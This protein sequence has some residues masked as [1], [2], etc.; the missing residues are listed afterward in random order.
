MLLEIVREDAIC[1]L[2]MTVP[3]VG[4]VTALTFRTAVDAIHR[5]DSSRLVAA[6]FGLTPRVHSSGEMEQIGRITKC[7]DTM[8]RAMLYE[9]ANVMMTRYRATSGSR[10]GRSASPRP[11]TT[12]RSVKPADD[13][14]SKGNPV[15]PL[16]KVS[17]FNSIPLPIAGCG[18]RSRQPSF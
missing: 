1:R 13:E 17:S 14:R 5:F 2:L 15:D 7:G 18:G 4:P 12:N 11:A 9:A 3:G 10:H 16:Q 8:V 6:V